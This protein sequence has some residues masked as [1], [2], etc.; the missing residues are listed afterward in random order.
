MAKRKAIV[1]KLSEKQQKLVTDNLGI[2]HSIG[3]KY[4]AVAVHRL[5]DKKSGVRHYLGYQEHFVSAAYAG[6]CHAAAR[7]DE[8]KGI[9]FSTYAWKCVRGY[10]ISAWEDLSAHIGSEKNYTAIVSFSDLTDDAFGNTG[11]DLETALTDD[12]SGIDS[13]SFMEAL[14]K[15]LTSD[16]LFMFQKKFV[17]SLA[18]S[19]I[20]PMLGITKQAV[21]FRF[22]KAFNKIRRNKDVV[23][24][25]Q[26]VA[27]DRNV[28]AKNDHPYGAKRTRLNA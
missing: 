13:T 27:H 8:S 11:R 14:R 10:C 19:D 15:V 26:S 28:K 18:Y 12:S 25:L 1:I 23:D 9:M 2:S 5:K 3:N 4:A 6:L 21:Q 24:Y 20:A 22:N 7:Y 16:E 17:E